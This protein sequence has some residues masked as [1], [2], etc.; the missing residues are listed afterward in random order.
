MT[1]NLLLLAHIASVAAW[2]GANF[3]QL[4]V[5]PRFRALGGE[6]ATQWAR[7]G[8]FLGQRYYNIVGI[9]VALTGISLVMHGHWHW[10][11][12]VLVGIAM[13]VIGALTGV[14]GFDRLFKRE[15]AARESGDDATAKRITHNIT[16]LALMD[17]FLILI[18][19]LAMID[20]WKGAIG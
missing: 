4:V 5:G 16:S 7:T 10:Q 12:F 8:Q 1:R 2:L 18:T 3:L 14:F 9:L 19:M 6:V 15:I 13:V 20:K 17:S 11:G